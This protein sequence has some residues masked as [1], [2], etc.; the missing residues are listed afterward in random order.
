LQEHL[1]GLP[2]PGGE[3]EVDLQPAPLLLPQH[4]Q[5]L[6]G[7]GASL[8]SVHVPPSASPDAGSVSR[9]VVPFPSTL[10]QATSPPWAVTISL[11]MASPRPVPVSSLWPGM[12]KNRSNTCGRYSAGMPTPV[13]ATVSVTRL[14][15]AAA[16]SVTLPPAGV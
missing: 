4:R 2:D 14:S 16:D 3:A 8:I 12:R 11:T 1:V 9:N 7:R 10:S 5:E 13:S 15:L 6:L